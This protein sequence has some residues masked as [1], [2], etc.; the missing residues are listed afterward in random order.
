MAGIDCVISR[1]INDID[2]F[3]SMDVLLV[4]TFVRIVNLRSSDVTGL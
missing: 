4:V 1:V 2:W 3:C